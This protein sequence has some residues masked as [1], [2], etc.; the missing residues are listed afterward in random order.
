MKEILQGNERKRYFHI[1]T[2]S[3]HL[4]IYDYIFVYLFIYP[5]IYIYL[6]IYLPHTFVSHLVLLVLVDTLV[7]HGV[8]ALHLHA[9]NRSDQDIYW[10]ELQ[11]MLLLNHQSSFIS[12]TNWKYS[13]N[14]T[15][16]VR[17][18]VGLLIGQ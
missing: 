9:L 4:T 14:I 6:F 5:S 10:S 11:K 13:F 12:S 16:S 7:L 18:P 1:L 17:R 8:R 2:K 15:L 3:I